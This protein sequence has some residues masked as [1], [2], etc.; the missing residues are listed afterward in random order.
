M[1]CL[2]RPP[3]VEAFRFSTGSVTLPLGLAYI[4]A[5]LEAAGRSVHVVDAVGEGPSVRTRYYKGYLIGL[6]L[7]EVVRRVPADAQWIGITTIF[8]H[9]WPAVVKLVE[10][11]KAAYPDKKIVLGGEHVTSLPEFCLATS[12]ADVLVL[13]EGEEIV[14][15]LAAV[16][17]DGGSLDELDGIAY[18]EGERIHVNRRR[19]RRIDVDAIAPP[20]W[21]HFDVRGY[22][23]HRF[24]G[25]MY[26]PELTIPMLA[27]RGCPYQCTYCSAPNMWTPRWVPRDPKLVADEIE[28]W[29]TQHGARNF[30]FQ[31]LT[32]IIQKDWIV[33]FCREILD[34]GLEISWQLPTGTRSEAI[35]AEVAALLKRS[36]MISMSYAP[37]SGSETTRRLIKKKMNTERL[38]ESIDAA[39]GADLNVSAFLVLGFPHD[40]R[41]HF[42][43]NLPFVDRLAAAGVPDISIGYYMALPGTELF[44]SLYDDGD[45]VLDR[46]YFRHILD[47]LSIWPLQSYCA[48]LSRVALFGWKVRLF[49][50]FYGARRRQRPRLAPGSPV[51]RALSGIF[52]RRHATKLETALLNATTS[53]WH[54]L[55]TRFTRNWL[56]RREERR[57]FEGW[58]D[59]YRQVRHIRS[60]ERPTATKPADIEELHRK[61]AIAML[62]ADHDLAYSF[63]LSR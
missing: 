7:E 50:R 52:R 34:R 54:I 40:R 36:G 16:L 14:V 5:A 2:V 59:V 11:L 49:A 20:A 9:E 12:K 29:V 35:D 62:R 53:A 32:A 33:A 8:T 46:A 26:S 6:A 48:N 23:A 37:E 25:G 27:T 47:S 15:D 24:V 10:L 56:P 39:V 3:A 30:P 57:M 61:N 55:R 28:M 19:P 17:A 58:D 21:R 42:A 60:A 45:I 41:E 31:D 22:H 18:R 1:I 13:G 4:A 38:F 43:E 51:W 44:H 63:T